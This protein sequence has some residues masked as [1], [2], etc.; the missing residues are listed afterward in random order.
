[1]PNLRASLK[2][3]VIA[4]RALA[5]AKKFHPLGIN[6]VRFQSLPASIARSRQRTIDTDLDRRNALR[7]MGWLG[8]GTYFA[9]A[10]G[11]PRLRA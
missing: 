1:L 5:I 3:T 7:C 4:C 6:R 10:A 2:S 8:A 11:L 9:V